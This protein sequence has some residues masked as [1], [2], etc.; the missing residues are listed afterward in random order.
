MS[1]RDPSNID[2]CLFL[3]NE[4]VMDRRIIVFLNRFEKICDI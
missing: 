4:E 1:P 2:F 3:R